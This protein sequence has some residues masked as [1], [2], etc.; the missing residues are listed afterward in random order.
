MQAPL[1]LPCSFLFSAGISCY[2]FPSSLSPSIIGWGTMRSIVVYSKQ[3]QMQQRAPS[4]KGQAPAAATT[5]HYVEDRGSTGHVCS[6]LPRTLSINAP[7]AAEVIS[8]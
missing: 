3:H 2:L 1:H 8:V 7:G 5:L 4:S 6:A